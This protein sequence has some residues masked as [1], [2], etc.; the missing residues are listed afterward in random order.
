MRLQL[1]FAI[2]A[3]L[4]AAGLLSS[5]AWIVWQLVET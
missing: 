3:G 1:E 4:L 2:I 5:F